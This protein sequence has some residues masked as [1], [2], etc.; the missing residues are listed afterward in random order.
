MLQSSGA[1]TLPLSLGLREVYRIRDCG[2]D[3]LWTRMI[4]ASLYNNS[5]R[6]H[7]SQCFRDFSLEF[8]RNGTIKSKRSF[9]FIN[10]NAVSNFWA[11]PVSPYSSFWSVRSSPKASSFSWIYPWSILSVCSPS[12]PVYWWVQ[13]DLVAWRSL[14]SCDHCNR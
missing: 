4:F 6:H 11:V 2:D 10:V 5:A 3:S 12:S 1:A 13:C 7:T 14:H 9:E 8:L